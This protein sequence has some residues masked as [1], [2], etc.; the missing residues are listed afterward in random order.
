MCL[1]P[2]TRIEQIGTRYIGELIERQIGLC[3]ERIAQKKEKENKM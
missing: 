2:E 3:A 1:C